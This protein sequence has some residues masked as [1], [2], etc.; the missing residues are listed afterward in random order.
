MSPI[1]V[2]APNK[3][4]AANATPVMVSFTSLLSGFPGSKKQQNEILN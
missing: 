2:E 1:I 3:N 4:K